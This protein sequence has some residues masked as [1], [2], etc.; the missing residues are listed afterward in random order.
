MALPPARHSEQVRSGREPPGQDRED[1][2]RSADHNLQLRECQ[3]DARMRTEVQA[4]NRQAL[5][6]QV[7]LGAGDDQL[8]LCLVTGLAVVLGEG[9]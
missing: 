1:L 3:G 6:G 7:G 8:A 2:L 4:P 9:R 5:G